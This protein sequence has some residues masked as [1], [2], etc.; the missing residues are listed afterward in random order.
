MLLAK[1]ISAFVRIHNMLL[2][3]EVIGRGF[4]IR[5]LCRP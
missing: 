5:K 2:S 1:I 3:S 4:P